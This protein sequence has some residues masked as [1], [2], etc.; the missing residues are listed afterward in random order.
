MVLAMLSGVSKEKETNRRSLIDS[1]LCRP[2]KERENE[3]NME[4]CRLLTKV[5]FCH[6]T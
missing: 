2:E 6:E 5:N 4:M 1:V 3:S